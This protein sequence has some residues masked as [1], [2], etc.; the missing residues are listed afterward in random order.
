VQQ[1]VDL[2][3]GI[4]STLDVQMEI[5]AASE[6][7]VVEATTAGVN[8][9]DAS[10]GNPLS[11]EQVSSLPSLDLNP[12]GLLSL[13]PGVAY[14]P[15][16]SDTAGGYGGVSDFD[17]RSGS[18]NGARSDQTN[19]TLDGVDVNDPQKGYA[20]TSV[21]RVTQASLAE[22]RT[23]TTNYTA[24]AGSRSSAAQV[25]L[26]TKSGTNAVHGSAYY[27]H[28]N[29]AFNAND[30]FLNRA[31]IPEP[32]FRRHIYGAALG[33]PIWKNRIYL[34]GNYERLQENLFKS[35]ER[36]VPSMPFR[37]GVFIYQCQNLPGYANCPTTDTVVKGVSGA[38][39]TI[40][41]GSY[42]LSPAEIRAID[43]LGVGPNPAVLAL[44]Q[45]FPVP[46]SSGTFDGVNIV[47]YRFGAP[48]NNFFNTYIARA[49][50]HLDRADKHTVF[51]RGTLMDDSL[52]TEPQFPGLPSKQTI[53]NNSKG[54][55]V[56]YTAVLTPQVV[57]NFR[58]GFT[59]IGE[60][61]AGQRKAEFVDFRFISNLKI[62]DLYKENSSFGRTIPQHHFRDDLS[63]NKGRHTLGMGGELRFT[64]TNKFS[65]INSFHEFLINPSWL[66]DGG[67]S[68]EPGSTNCDRPGCF[69][70]PA[71][72]T[73]S[74]SLRDGLTEMLGP[75]SQIDALY[76]FDHT[77]TTLAEGTP[78]RRRFAVN[79]YE[80]Y[81]QDQWRATPSLTLTAG[82]RY[83]IS[84]PPW[85]Q[86]G[87]QV[88][89]TPSLNTWFSCRE[90]AMKAG[91]PTST[92]GQIET[93]LGGPVNHAPGY[94]D[95]DYKNISP[96][97]AFAW[98]PR[99]R[100]GI[101]GRILGDGKT[102]IR[103]GWSRVYDRI[104]NGLA[105]TFDEVG[106]F[107]LSTDITSFFGGCDIGRQGAKLGAITG[108]QVSLDSS[109]WAAYGHVR[110]G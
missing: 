94:Y 70:V 104:G 26:V 102:A 16:Q 108:C 84:T 63:W 78:V 52:A 18:V 109:I 48:V 110:L 82:L 100:G 14:I 61:T 106:S 77:S 37:D 75:I 7:V 21:L 45:Q 65:N 30:F 4:T 66:P 71:N 33:G 80:T 9:S 22:F 64:R 79:E 67:R 72:I 51:W 53:V 99:F 76:N 59:R 49:D 8:T 11:G 55:A 6:Q 69:A 89:P 13:Q 105:T 44:D 27:A 41:A 62:G 28:R 60:S 35:A 93:N 31:G 34:F 43:P 74:S 47:G 85:E 86:N 83:Y 95:T 101:A 42:G 24:D 68:I 57:N 103:G 1:N 3:V 98:S 107:G 20:F 39:Y 96:R 12:A 2:L 92:C 87:N 38:S 90:K 50:F 40:P 19:V 91:L 56:G 46:N 5:G 29:E 73:G 88:V 58:W 23:T 81:F 36:D 15:V 25:Q 54:F 10:I 17:G 32:K 97:L